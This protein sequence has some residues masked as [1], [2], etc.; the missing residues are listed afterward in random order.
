VAQLKIESQ[1]SITLIPFEKNHEA[2]FDP[3]YSL[4]ISSDD[5]ES[6]QS[7]FTCA[8]AEEDWY[9]LYTKSERD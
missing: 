1:L 2:E 4:N 7:Y 8:S 6:D 5:A 9:S 3:S